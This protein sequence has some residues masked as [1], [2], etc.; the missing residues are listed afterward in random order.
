[1]YGISKKMLNPQSD[2]SPESLLR[3]FPTF[4]GRISE[5]EIGKLNLKLNTE[6]ARLLLKFTNTL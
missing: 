1:M 3:Y 6:E 2:S 5:Y 4:P